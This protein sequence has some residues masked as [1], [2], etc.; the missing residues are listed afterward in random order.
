MPDTSRRQFLR[1][2]ILGL[3]AAAFGGILQACKSVTT[4]SM[5]PTSALPDA[6]ATA[7]ATAAATLPESTPVPSTTLIASA[8]P[9][10]SAGYPD[11]AVVRAGEPEALGAP[12]DRG[13]GR[14]GAVRAARARP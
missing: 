10:A 12:R 3:G 1:L 4:P 2:A 8:T 9:A 14:H 7:A 5:G 6:T 13:S 11:L